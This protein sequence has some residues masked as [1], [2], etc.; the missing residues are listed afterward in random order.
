MEQ[1]SKTV[2][3]WHG[4]EN[5]TFD[6]IKHIYGNLDKLSET[7]VKLGY[8]PNTKT[9]IKLT[10]HLNISEMVALKI[11]RSTKRWKTSNHIIKCNPKAFTSVE[12]FSTNA[13]C[14]NV[15]H[16]CKKARCFSNDA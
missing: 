14:S 1:T 9:F 16:G 5:L 8:I 4:R 10:N 12:S 3:A 7:F 6:V 2:F 11:P 13:S 15:K